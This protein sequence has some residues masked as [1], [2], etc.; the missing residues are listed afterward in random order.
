MVVTRG[1][2]HISGR[3]RPT[4]VDCVGQVVSGAGT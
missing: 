1:T 4:P 2:V 3:L